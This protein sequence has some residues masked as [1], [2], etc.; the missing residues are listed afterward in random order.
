MWQYVV[1]AGGNYRA[2]LAAYRAER[3][4]LEVRLGVPVPLRGVPAVVGVL[5]PVD[6]VW[7][8]FTRPRVGASRAGLHTI[9]FSNV[10][11]S[12]T[13]SIGAPD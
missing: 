12:T 10:S 11:P 2:S 3:M 1:R 5:A 8:I 13:S 4:S 7:M 6:V 9:G